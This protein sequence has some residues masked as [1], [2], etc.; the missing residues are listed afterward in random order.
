[1]PIKPP[2][3]SYGDNIRFHRDLYSA[4]RRSGYTYPDL[5][6]MSVREALLAY[7]GS[8]DAVDARLGEGT[9]YGV[10]QPLR[11]RSWWRKEW[12]RAVAEH[13]TEYL[14]QLDALEDLREA[15]HRCQQLGV[16]NQ[17]IRVAVQTTMTK[18]GGIV[19]LAPQPQLSQA[20]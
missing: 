9:Y 2:T 17:D 8:P 6:S 13:K 3:T 10:Q 15:V 18:P 16:S 12:R 7:Y 5:W 11:E 20:Q 1:M 4:L 19:P 14:A